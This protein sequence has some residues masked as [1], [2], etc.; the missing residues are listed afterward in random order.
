MA[1]VEIPGTGG[2]AITELTG[3]VSAVGP[4]SAVATLNSG[5]DVTKLAD[6]TVSNTKFQYINSL[7][8]NAQE[9]L[10]TKATIVDVQVF[11]ASGTWTKPSGASLVEV[12]CIGGG[13][14]GASG[15]KQASGTATSG[16][17]SGASAAISNR[18]FAASLL[19]STETVTVAA[20]GTGGASVTTDSTAANPGGAGGSTTFGTWLRAGSGNGAGSYT[21]G[22]G[23]A[24]T[25]GS[26]ALGAFPGSAGRA[27]SVGGQ[28]LGP[29]PATGKGCNVGGAGGGISAGGAASVGTGWTNTTFNDPN[30]AN[31][32]DPAI[33]G[34]PTNGQNGG[35]WAGFP[36]T[37]GASS[38]T[39]NAMNAGVSGKYGTSGSGGGSSLNG[40]NKNSGAG[41]DGAVGVCVVITW[42]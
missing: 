33:G 22:A 27:G 40:A 20:G 18:K 37:G 31:V 17:G 11:E 35:Y 10:N 15:T 30:L 6:G 42:F 25:A 21:T 16:G 26:S 41:G 5:I 8:S 39:G 1:F 2:D 13:G 24:G 36:G 12:I 32:N 7:S 4:G 29:A 19:G 28:G 34:S 3:D 38:V 23:P 9:Q 14:G